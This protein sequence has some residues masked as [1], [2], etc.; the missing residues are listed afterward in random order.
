L[1]PGG[2]VGS[3]LD[4][5]GTSFDSVKGWMGNFVTEKDLTPQKVVSKIQ[6]FVEVSEDRLDY[7]A[8]F[9]DMTTNYYEH[10]GIQTLARRLIERAVAEI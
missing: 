5:I 2:N 3:Q 9:L 4:F 8:A 7:L 6:S 10:T 1:V